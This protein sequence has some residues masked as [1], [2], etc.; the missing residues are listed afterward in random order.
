MIDKILG[1][2]NQY[3][4]RYLCPSWAIS[5]SWSFLLGEHMTLAEAYSAEALNEVLGLL[6]ERVR[7]IGECQVT[8]RSL[9]K[10]IRTRFVL[11]MHA[12][13]RICNSIVDDLLAAGVLERW[14]SKPRC[15]I[16]RVNTDRVFDN[17]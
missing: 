12:A 2:I 7:R 10:I 8:S 11:N 9:R 4:R 15:R 17:V 5:M 16:Y 3:G 6:R 14:D 13:T 1:V